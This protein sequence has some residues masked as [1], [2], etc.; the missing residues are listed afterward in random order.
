MPGYL[1]FLCNAKEVEN[2]VA[3]VFSTQGV[4]T[5]WN[6]L[7]AVNWDLDD[8]DSSPFRLKFAEFEEFIDTGPKDVPELYS[9]STLEDTRLSNTSRESITEYSP[10]TKDAA[11]LQG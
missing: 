7:G 1:L 9:Y 5:P 2:K 10:P 4:K 8:I 11:H 3:L 6:D